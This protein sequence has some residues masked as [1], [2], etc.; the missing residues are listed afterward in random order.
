VRTYYIDC[1]FDGHRGDLI[2]IA[3]VRDDSHSLYIKIPGPV[4]DPWVRDNVMTILDVHE[5]DEFGCVDNYTHVGTFIRWFIGDVKEFEIVADSPVDI[6]RF[7]DIL[8]TGSDGQWVNTEYTN[9]VAQVVNVDCYPTTLEGAIQHN[10]W[11]DAMALR[12]KLKEIS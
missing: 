11:W 5:A 4:K 2:S 7:F 8:S 1:E 9:I 10:A 3:L 6:S 12:Q